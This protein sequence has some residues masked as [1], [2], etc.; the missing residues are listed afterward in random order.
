M[1][2][3]IASVISLLAVAATGA[4]INMEYR[5]QLPGIGSVTSPVTGVLSKVGEQAPPALS[6]VGEALNKAGGKEDNNSSAASKPQALPPSKT[7]Q[8]LPSSSTL[9][10]VSATPLASALPKGNNAPKGGLGG[11]ESLL[12][13]L[14][15]K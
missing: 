9:P 8:T 14:G 10:K 2:P 7:S 12:G 4:P 3:V 15:L 6:K 5:R 11:L 13:G 1:K